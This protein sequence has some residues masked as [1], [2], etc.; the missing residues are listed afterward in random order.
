M[1]LSPD[2]YKV[3]SHDDV[4]IVMMML[5]SMVKDVGGMVDAPP[6]KGGFG[7]SNPSHPSVNPF[8]RLGSCKKMYLMIH[9]KRSRKEKITIL[10]KLVSSREHAMSSMT[11]RLS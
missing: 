4:H 1:I 8:A 3:A 5:S 6:T 7:G 9:C 11:T 2:Q 10:V